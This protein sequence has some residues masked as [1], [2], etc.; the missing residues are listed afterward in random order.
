MQYK[1][2]DEEDARGDY[3]DDEENEMDGLD[4]ELGE[5][6]MLDIAEK[7]FYKIA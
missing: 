2:E 7:C 4:D 6:E 5:E 3:E 1:G